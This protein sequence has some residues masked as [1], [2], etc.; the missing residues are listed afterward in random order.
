MNDNKLIIS[1][2]ALA[3]IVGGSVWYF[4]R[5][6]APDQKA[7]IINQA[8]EEVAGQQIDE[9]QP[10]SQNQADFGN[11]P[12][13]DQANYQDPY[14]GDSN[15]PVTI[16]EY[17]SYGCGHCKSFNET[18]FPILKQKYIDTGQVRFMARQLFGNSQYPLADLCAAEQGK[19]WDYH[20][21]L[22]KNSSEIASQEETA[23][24]LKEF[25]VILGLDQ[26]Q[27][28]A[29]YDS[30]RYNEQITKWGEEGLAK[31][32]TGVPAFFIN[33]QQI[34]GNQPIAEF[35]KA[36]DAELNK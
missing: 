10:D 26:T 7:A 19:Y 32:L 8:A 14:L 5:N 3:I 21:Y 13:V 16:V 27:F 28:D 4:G 17:F 29:C 20:D 12:A 2:L 34:M 31:G 36:I 22:F 9:N 11:Q 35:E 24:K 33:D 15:A 25:A 18:T 23:S 1:G 30:A 6:A